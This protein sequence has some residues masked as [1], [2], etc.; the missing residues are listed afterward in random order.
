MPQS[1]SPCAGATGR[2]LIWLDAGPGAG[3]AGTSCCSRR[4]A[5]KTIEGREEKTHHG[6]G[7]DW[8]GEGCVRGARSKPHS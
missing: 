6:F 4:F 8:L 2:P 5:Y 3:L 1:I 7:A